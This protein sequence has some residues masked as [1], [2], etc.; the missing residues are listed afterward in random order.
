MYKR[1][2]CSKS[3][4]SPIKK[5]PSSASPWWVYDS[6]TLEPLRHP[7]GCTA[8]H[9]G[10]CLRGLS[11]EECLKHCDKTEGVDSGYFVGTEMAPRKTLCVPIASDRAPSRDAILRDVRNKSCFPSTDNSLVDTAFF[12]KTKDSDGP[13][14]HIP[15]DANCV[16]TGDL[17]VLDNLDE[18]NISEVQRAGPISTRETRGLI[19]IVSSRQEG[20]IRFG[21]LVSFV[22]RRPDNSEFLVSSVRGAASWTRTNQ[23]PDVYNERFQILPVKKAGKDL[24]T[25]DPSHT[26]KMHMGKLEALQEDLRYGV[27]FVIASGGGMS[28][29]RIDKTGRGQLVVPKKGPSGQIS[30]DSGDIFRLE[31]IGNGFYCSGGSC[32]SVKLSDCSPNG[33][34]LTYKGKKVFRDPNCYSSCKWNKTTKRVNPTKEVV[35]TVTKRV[36]ERKCPPLESQLS[37]LRKF[38]VKS[39]VSFQ[40]RMLTSTTIF[41]YSAIL[42]IILIVLL[43]LGVATKRL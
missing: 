28:I 4:Q 31:P 26:T 23:S 41:M 43:D 11:K 17:T 32:T 13:H 19:R 9:D 7:Y 2:S 22:Q 21:D 18:G 33:K 16:F 24:I 42:S 1:S 25:I 36:N 39:R 34:D 12:L 15:N 38:F 35:S 40:G 20:P 14:V 29:I 30:I 6:S 3:L 8:A 10:T 5:T 27:P 37:I